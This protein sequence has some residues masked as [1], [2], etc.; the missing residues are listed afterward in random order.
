MMQAALPLQGGFHVGPLFE[1]RKKRPLSRP[2]GKAGMI[3]RVQTRCATLKWLSEEQKAQIRELH[4]PWNLEVIHWKENAI[5][6]NFWW[7]NMPYTQLEL[8]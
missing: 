2:L 6:G 3:H 1:I 7:P 4:V 8:I 5:K